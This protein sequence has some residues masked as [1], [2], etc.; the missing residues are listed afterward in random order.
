MLL[1]DMLPSNFKVFSMNPLFGMLLQT[2]WW[3][4]V[5]KVDSKNPV[6][7]PPGS[8]SVRRLNCCF[9][10]ALKVSTWSTALFSTRLLGIPAV[11]VAYRICYVWQMSSW[12][13]STAIVDST[14]RRENVFPT[15]FFMPLLPGI[16]FRSTMQDTRSL[17]L[18]LRPFYLGL[19]KDPTQGVPCNKRR[20]SSSLQ[21]IDW[22]KKRGS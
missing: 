3:V 14:M 16:N 22:E 10:G 6:W 13:Q 4:D 8:H 15:A 9:Q 2:L 21:T 5:P 1:W 11:Q 12:W 20:P 19:V 18:R 7:G 17:H